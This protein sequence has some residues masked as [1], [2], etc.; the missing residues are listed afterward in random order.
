MND[1]TH[2]SAVLREPDALK[3]LDQLMECASRVLDRY[4][5]L[6]VRKPEP[7]PLARAA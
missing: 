5:R 4:G 1:W 3:G 7:Q 6:P 2:I